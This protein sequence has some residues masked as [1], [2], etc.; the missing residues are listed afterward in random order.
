MAN[1]R[2]NVCD[3]QEAS[4][5]RCADCGAGIHIDGAREAGA[6]YICQA[7]LP[8]RMAAD[9]ADEVEVQVEAPGDA[10]PAAPLD[11][12]AAVKG[13]KE[14]TDPTCACDWCKVV[15]PI[16]A[17]LAAVLRKHKAASKPAKVDAIIRVLGEA[18]IV[19]RGHSFWHR[20]AAFVATMVGSR[21]AMVADREA[22]A[23]HERMRPV[24]E[25]ALADAGIDLSELIRDMPK[26]PLH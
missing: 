7:C 9:D 14:L 3:R 16:A 25:K 24:V 12:A 2:F 4:A 19:Y 20:D 23:F 8:A 11:E 18:A 26:E 21:L 5:D 15:N 1:G 22:S 13:C 6:T 10:T 17:D